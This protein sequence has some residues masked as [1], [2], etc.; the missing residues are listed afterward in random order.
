MHFK[1]INTENNI[2]TTVHGHSLLQQLFFCPED[3]HYCLNDRVVAHFF[4]Q[5]DTFP[6]IFSFISLYYLF[7]GV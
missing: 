7:K 1:N 3:A 6:C 5:G 2:T 4:Q